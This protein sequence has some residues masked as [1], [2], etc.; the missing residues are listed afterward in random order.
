MDL[1]T[2]PT[3][4][5]HP[6]NEQLA[7][8]ATPM[9]TSYGVE[10]VEIQHSYQHA[11]LHVYMVVY[12]QNGVSSEQC[13]ALHRA[14]LPRLKVHLAQPHIML[15]VSSPGSTRQLKSLR[16][17]SLFCGRR[18]EVLLPGHSEW[19]PMRLMQVEGEQ[20]LFQAGA[21]PRRLSYHAISKAR[22]DGAAP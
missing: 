14:L 17:F 21:A 13:A 7:H 20:L 16:E 9:A 2:K 18:L 8:I 5:S 1:E 10:I 12:A 22:L 15:Q 4:T 11:H 6:L 19:I 3:A